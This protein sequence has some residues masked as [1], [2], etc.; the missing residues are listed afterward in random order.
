M[1]GGSIGKRKS[2]DLELKAFS[3]LRDAVTT[4][5]HAG[6]VDDQIVLKTNRLNGK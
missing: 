2:F 4:T 1:G 5:R 6:C 3:F